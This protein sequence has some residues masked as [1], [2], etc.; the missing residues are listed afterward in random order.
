MPR[1]YL[2]P[3]TGEEIPAPAASDGVGL[4]RAAKRGVYRGIEQTAGMAD[5]MTRIAMTIQTGQ[6][7]TEEALNPLTVPA[8]ELSRRA[9][10]PIVPREQL[11][12][13]EKLVESGVA[14]VVSAAP[15]AIMPGGTIGAIVKRA[16]GE[17]GRGVTGQIGSDLAEDLGAG[18]IVQFLAGI[19][20]ALAPSAVGRGATHARRAVASAGRKTQEVFHSA[21]GK[22]ADEARR[23]LD[24]E[25]AKVGTAP[26][27]AA[28][29]DVAPR[30]QSL[31]RAVL[32]STGEGGNDLSNAIVRLRKANEVAIDERLA[33]RFPTGPTGPAQ[34]AFFRAREQLVRR[35]D[36][37]YLA[38]GDLAGMP[39]AGVKAQA[40]AIV[41]EAVN[42]GLDNQ[43]PRSALRKIAEFGD[44]TNLNRLRG[45]RTELGEAATKAQ[46]AGNNTR[47]RY[48]LQLK[49]SIDETLE[50][51]ARESGAP[52]IGALR[53]AISTA[54]DKFQLVGAAEK[55]SK[56]FGSTRLF[57]EDENMRRGFQKYILNS[58]R[59][60]QEIGRL[61]L[62]IGDDPE[63]WQ[64]LQGLMR[65]TVFDEDLARLGK[66][67]AKT[68]L[69]KHRSAFDAL[70]GDGATKAALEFN[71]RVRQ[72]RSGVTGTR[73]E[74]IPAGSSIPG[75]R[76]IAG[77]AIVVANITRGD[78]FGALGNTIALV[79]RGHVA[80]ADEMNR[81]LAAALADPRV[82][83]G[84]LEPLGP[85]QFATW[86]GRVEQ[87]LLAAPTRSGITASQPAQ[88]GGGR[89]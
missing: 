84:F 24:A 22:N 1:V 17:I 14:G 36:D 3:M 89:R 68:L 49:E 82:A 80:G 76:E 15:T 86:A 70:Y 29:E 2:D 21:V 16:I 19:G 48:L 66:D 60:T 5:L 12:G 46:R 6:I 28:L 62:L 52:E 64:G 4:A 44:A 38:A 54:R 23:L 34:D 7:P 9:L 77:N 79:T 39:T 50:T 18:P 26:T 43:L 61:K 8:Q 78:Y 53:R 20:G 41:A 85:Q 47:A 42:S 31:E 11:T 72:L 88:P 71:D 40:K 13:A 69:K 10:G 51:V 55:G 25:A 59:P 45:L 35:V 73:F 67:A 32:K 57:L 83:R 65:D 37:A 27:A 87:V 33:S 58:K 75:L 30:I 81:L 74:A 63:A 56:A